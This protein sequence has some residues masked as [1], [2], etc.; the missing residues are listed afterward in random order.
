MAS[1]HATSVW[2]CGV[3][4]CGL[5]C[6]CI[7]LEHRPPMGRPVLSAD[8]PRLSTYGGGSRTNG[9]HSCEDARTDSTQAAAASL[10]PLPGL[11]RWRR[12]A[13]PPSSC[14]AWWWQLP[15]IHLG[16]NAAQLPAPL[17]RRSPSAQLMWWWRL[18]L[19]GLACMATSTTELQ[20]PCMEL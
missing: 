11:S 3:V 19:A 15:A 14:G 7:C 13:R 12:C 8:R 10:S 1:S 6:P 9:A 2:G 17:A 16:N 20:K 4:P 18:P 5:A